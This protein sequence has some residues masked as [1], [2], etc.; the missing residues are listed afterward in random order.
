[1]E[2]ISISELKTR[3]NNGE[4]LLVDFFATWCGPCK[5]LTPRLENIEK[6]FLNISF[7]KIDIEENMDGLGEYGVSSVPTVLICD[8]SDVKFKSVGLNTDS[9]YKGL[10]EKL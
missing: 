2:K 6:S 7:V 10:L 9:F 3:Q 5:A 1:M 8:G 4:K